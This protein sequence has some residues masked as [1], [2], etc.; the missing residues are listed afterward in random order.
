MDEK[1]IHLIGRIDQ[2]VRD[3]FLSNPTEVSILA[4][5]LMPLFIEKDIFQKDYREGKPI[6]DLL[7]LLDKE[8]ALHLLRHCKVIR[9]A[10]NRNWYFDRA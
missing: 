9:K 7:R 3:H 6:R 4:K 5:N 1:K 8:N 10:T 2:I